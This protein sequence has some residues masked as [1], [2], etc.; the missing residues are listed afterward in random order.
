[1]PG[2]PHEEQAVEVADSNAPAT[3]S[4]VGQMLGSKGSRA[5]LTE[6][7]AGLAGSVPSVQQVFS[8]S[9]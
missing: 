9:A 8:F 6:S 7:V 5:L 1:M 2:A 3:E 4:V